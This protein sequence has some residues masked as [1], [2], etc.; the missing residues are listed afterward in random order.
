[1]RLKEL[2]MELSKYKLGEL[3]ELYSEQCNKPNLSI[4]EVSGINRDKEFFE[5]A[6]QVGQDTSKYQIVPPKY[7]A[8]NLMHVGRDEVLPI[9]LN[10]TNKSKIVS[11]AYTVFCVANEILLNE[12]LFI[13][14]KS[15]EIDRYFWLHTDASVRDGMSWADFCDLEIK[16]PSLAIQQK[17]INIYQALSNNQQSYEQGLEDLKLL[18]DAYIEDLR[19][20][21]RC[22]EIGNYITESNNKVEEQINNYSVQ[23][24]VGISSIDKNFMK[25]KAD[26]VGLSV[27]GYKI[28]KSNEIAFNPNTARMGERI[29]IALNNLLNNFLVSAIYPVFQTN[30]NYLLAEYLMM[31]FKR[32]EFDRYVRFHSWGSARETFTWEDMCEVK[33]P[34]PDIKIQQAIVD[35]YNCYIT[36]KE[37]NEKLKIQLKNICPILIK[38]A[39]EEASNE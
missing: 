22:E 13:M 12:Y 37:I 17:Y 31:W 39:L 32:S 9:S 20:K 29:P 25:T 38:G 10:H 6:K 28:V 36:R 33:I 2:A 27:K 16:L 3:I 18:C 30:K 4:N 19:K 34:I 14:L 1:M 23:D 5:P 8:C 7:F 24:I 11:P 26:V 21:Y 15:K 35:I